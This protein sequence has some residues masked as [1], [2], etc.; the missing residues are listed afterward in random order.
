MSARTV[1]FETER[2]RPLKRFFS[3]KPLMRFKAEDLQAY[4]QARLKEG[5]SGRTVNM[6]IGVLRRLFQ[7]A[8]AKPDWLVAH[9]TAVLAAST[10][11]RSV[12]LRHLR[13][14]D[15]DLFGQVVHVRRSKTPAGHR[16]NSAERRCAGGPGAAARAGRVQGRP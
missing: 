10:T 7:T 9:C 16:T 5:I 3:D 11:C 15:V 14:K 13:W 4:Q 1:Q 8:A 12:E 6:E 2:L